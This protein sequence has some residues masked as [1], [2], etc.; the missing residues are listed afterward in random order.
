M[1]GHIAITVE[2][3]DAN[4]IRVA[5]ANMLNSDGSVNGISDTGVT[6][7][8]RIDSLDDPWILGWYRRL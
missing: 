4:H 8:T 5:E 6:S 3:L 2:V 1:D 7:N